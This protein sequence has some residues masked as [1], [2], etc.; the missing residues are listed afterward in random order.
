MLF[1]L[2]AIWQGV[3]LIRWPSR[4]HVALTGLTGGLTLLTHPEAATFVLIS[5]GIFLLSFGR[6]PR[7]IGY[8][9]ASGVIGVAVAL[10]WLVI[11]TMKHGASVLLSAADTRSAQFVTTLRELVF[12]HFI[13]AVDLNLFLGIGLL[14]LFLQL[15]R[16]RYLL[17]AWVASVSVLIVAAGFTFAMV[18]WA[19]L[20]AIV[21]AEVILPA[22]GRLAPHP[23]YA[24]AV[25]T[26]GLVGA[27]LLSSLAT[28][29]AEDAPLHAVSGEQRISMEWASVHLPSDARVAVIT[30]LPWQID[31]TSEWFPV[32]S[33]RHS[34]AT[35]QGYEWMP[36]FNQRRLSHGALQQV[37]ARRGLGCVETWGKHYEVEVDY[38]YIPKGKLGGLG[39]RGDCCPAIR[40]EVKSTLRVVYDG[41]GATI[42]RINVRSAPST[43]AISPMSLAGTSR[44]GLG[45]GR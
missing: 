35:P 14:G 38:V 7:A 2:L 39:S 5:L 9:V 40:S 28:G 21:L 30:G 13:G 3:R 4:T 34:V 22:A 12:G 29:Y 42:A 31:A 44:S 25:M 43:S 37:C 11:V 33:Q 41:P 32:L 24:T 27:G 16:R 18:P 6:S 45:V 20:T 36:A 17:P 15:G 10:P 1:A 19:I 23:P 8:V 26:A